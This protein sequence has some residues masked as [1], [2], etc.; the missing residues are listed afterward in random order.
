MTTPRQEISILVPWPPKALWPNAR[1]H[2][3]VKAGAVKEARWEARVLS[4]DAQKIAGWQ[5]ANRIKVSVRAI[6]A[7]PGPLPDQDNIWAALKPFF[8]GMI[9]AGVCVSDRPEHFELG[10]IIFERGA[11]SKITLIVR[12]LE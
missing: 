10:Q 7:G 1:P 5:T 11:K 12:R 8:D 4:Q 3:A 6:K 9:D 2:W